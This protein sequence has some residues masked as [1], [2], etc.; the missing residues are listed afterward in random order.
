[1]GQIRNLRRSSGI[2]VIVACPTPGWVAFPRSTIWGGA[3]LCW[4]PISGCSPT[5]GTAVGVGAVVGVG[6]RVGRGASG[7]RGRRDSRGSRSRGRR[8]HHRRDGRRRRDS[9]RGRLRRCCRRWLGSRD[10]RWRRHRR[11]LGRRDRNLGKRHRVWSFVHVDHKDGDVNPV[12]ASSAVRYQQVYAVRGLYFKVKHRTGQ[13]VT[14]VGIDAEGRTVQATQLISQRV[15]VCV[16]R[17]R[18][19]C[20]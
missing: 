13:Q 12:G 5:G 8:R 20:R 6:R 2:T 4:C 18:P 11:G 15:I 19:G 9:S 17:Q 3:T 1:M 16:C 10:L 14:G 7:R